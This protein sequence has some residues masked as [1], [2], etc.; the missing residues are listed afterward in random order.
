MDYTTRIRKSHLWWMRLLCV[1]MAA[2]IALAQAPVEHV[3]HSFSNFP[4]G[5]NPYAPLTRDAQ[6]N[7]YGTT[8][9]GGPAN[10]GVV[11]KLALSGQQ[12]ALYS[13]TGGADGGCPYGGVVRSS[14]GEIYGT[15]TYGGDTA[16]AGVVFKLDVSGRETVLHTF[17]GGTD[18]AHPYGGVTTDSA[19]NLYGTTYGGGSTNC[20]GGCGV[21]YK[22]GAGGQETVLHTFVGTADGANPY[23][24]VTLDSAGNMYGTTYTG[25]AQALGTIYRLDAAD[26]LTVLYNGQPATGGGFYA[27]VILDEASNLYGTAANGDGFV[28]KLDGAG[29]Y[30]VLYTFRHAQGPFRPEGELVRD[31]QGNLYGTT[32]YGGT[33]KLGALYK[34]DSAGN[35][36]VLYSFPG[37]GTDL[38]PAGPNSGVIRDSAG[39]LYGTTAYGGMAGLVYRVDSSGRETTLCRF[40]PSAGGTFPGALAIGPGGDLY[41]TTYAGGAANAGVIYKVD[42]TGHETVL[43]TFT[44]ATDGSSPDSQ[45]VVLDSAGNLYGGT[46]GG[47]IASGTA[48]FGVIYKVDSSGQQTVLHTFTGGAD[49]GVPSGV[50]RDSA[51]NLYGD[52]LLGGASGAG[53]VFRLD[54]SGQE[55]VLHN[56]T[57]GSDGGSPEGGVILDPGGNLYGTTLYGGAAGYGVVYKLNP[58]GHETVLYSFPGGP[59]GALPNAGVIR[60]SA[61]N[62]YGTTAGGGGAAGEGGAGL[63]FQLTAAGQYSVIYTFTGGADGG[64]PH[65]VVRDAG[66]NLYGAVNVSTASTCAFNWTSSCGIIYRLAPSGQFTVL[67]TFPGE[68]DG[69]SSSDIILDPSG[70]ILGPGAG[71]AGGGGLIYELLMQ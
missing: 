8:C 23:A 51:G 50:V 12:T 2:A 47:G 34:L 9:Q 67:Y 7:L 36:S 29:K 28:Y 30:T 22:V 49:G 19:G 13:F 6:G 43:H 42:S 64:F 25:G 38:L 44:G 40:P 5:A 57:G 26:H 56:F 48:G 14:A 3:I 16:N 31:S 21:V 1:L 10:E 52:T 53:G 46:V 35:L 58:S 62:L 70:N 4:H 20:T 45:G 17:T 41:G 18:G 63:V 27:G 33:A 61:G 71:G 59:F 37:A 39:N 11:F 24:G 55:T 69:N 15:T 54:S 68:N 66:G 60:D 65:G 32:Q